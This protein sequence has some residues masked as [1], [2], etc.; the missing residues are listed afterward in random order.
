MGDSI[1]D[2]S[3]ID[4]P[5]ADEHQEDSATEDESE[6]ESFR[7]HRN[8][9]S[10]GPPDPFSTDVLPFSQSQLLPHDSTDS[11]NSLPS[12]V[13]DFHAMFGGDESYPDSFPMSLR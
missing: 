11:Q 4:L 3:T 5:V 2:E 8:D 6:D 13:K 9:E 7:V 10:T 12:A 1:S